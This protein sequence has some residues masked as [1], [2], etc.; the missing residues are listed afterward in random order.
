MTVLR[1]RGRGGAGGGNGEHGQPSDTWACWDPALPEMETCQRYRK[2][3]GMQRGRVWGEGSDVTSPH[4]FPIPKLT[5][6]G[7]LS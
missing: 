1:N 3:V 7:L 6:P 5:S 4:G 2:H